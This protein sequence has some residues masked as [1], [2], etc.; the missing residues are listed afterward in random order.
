MYLPSRAWDCTASLDIGQSVVCVWVWTAGILKFVTPVGF[1]RVLEL[2]N[3]VVVSTA[4]VVFREETSI[5]IEHAGNFFSTN[6][7]HEFLMPGLRASRLTC[8]W[9]RHET[10]LVLNLWAIADLLV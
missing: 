9:Y 6:N 3:T 7:P 5:Y 10:I 2:H 1:L 4:V 8:T